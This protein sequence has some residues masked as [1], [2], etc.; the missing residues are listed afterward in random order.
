MFL[1]GT[2]RKKESVNATVSFRWSRTRKGCWAVAQSSILV[3]TITLERLTK[4]G[5]ESITEYY[6]KHRFNPDLDFE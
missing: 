3:T 4:L 5:Y 1:F 2:I 6:T